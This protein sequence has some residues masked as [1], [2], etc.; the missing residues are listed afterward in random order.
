MREIRPGRINSALMDSDYS[1]PAVS[2]MEISRTCWRDS[3]ASSLL[4][5]KESA[6]LGCFFLGGRATFYDDLMSMCQVKML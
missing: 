6:A 4:L 5:F 2:T 1:T 3:T